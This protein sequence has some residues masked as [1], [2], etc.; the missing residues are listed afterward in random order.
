MKYIG[1]EIHPTG[2]GNYKA[3]I[4]GQPTD[5]ISDWRG[6]NFRRLTVPQQPRK[7]FETVA[8]ARAFVLS[9]F[10]EHALK[11]LAEKKGDGSSYP[12]MRNVYAVSFHK[13]GDK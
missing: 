11:D 5:H 6:C 4:W 2:K 1:T 12:E 13:Q 3:Y 9:T 8:E 7:G 10:G